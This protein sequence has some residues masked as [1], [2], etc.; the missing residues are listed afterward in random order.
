MK[1]IFGIMGVQDTNIISLD[2]EEFGGEIFE[3]S[4]Q[5]VYKKIA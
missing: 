1:F 3:K 5:T 2:N 4:K